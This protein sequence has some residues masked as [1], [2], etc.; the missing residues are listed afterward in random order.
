MAKAESKVHK[1]QVLVWLS[2]LNFPEMMISNQEW[3]NFIGYMPYLLTVYWWPEARWQCIRA[4]RWHDNI[5]HLCHG[6][7]RSISSGRR[8]INGGDTERSGAVGVVSSHREHL[9]IIMDV[10]RQ[11]KLKYPQ[12]DFPYVNVYHQYLLSQFTLGH[13]LPP[14]KNEIQDDEEPLDLSFKSYSSECSMSPPLSPATSDVSVSSS[15]SLS[16]PI[17]SIKSFTVD[18]MLNN[19]GRAKVNSKPDISKHKCDQCGKHFATSSNLSR[20]KQTHLEMSQENAK[21]CNIC[22]KMYVS[23]PA[24]NMHMLT[25]TNNHKCN[26]C[27]KS[28]S[29]PWLLQGHMRSH[30]GEKPYGCA[31]CGKKFADRSNLRAHMKIHKCK[32]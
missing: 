16:P 31:H 7:E 28:F 17:T 32:H 12:T 14:C 27:H 5:C 8:D 22:H 4:L 18:S 20:H 6:G 15:S 10:F 11:F 1:T 2:W 26:V 19:D 30:T 13:Q 25:H 24:L 9:S 3:P 23:V 21:S 29:R